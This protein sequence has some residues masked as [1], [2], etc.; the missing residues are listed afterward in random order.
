MTSHHPHPTNAA[1]TMANRNERATSSMPKWLLPI[2]KRRR[3]NIGPAVFPASTSA[4][5]SGSNHDHMRTQ[6]RPGMP[7]HEAEPSATAHHQSISTSPSF[8]LAADNS[9]ACA[10]KRKAPDVAPRNGIWIS[11][12]EGVNIM[13]QAEMALK[14]SRRRV[15]PSGSESHSKSAWIVAN[16]S[17][18]GGFF[19]LLLLP[20]VVLIIFRD[21]YRDLTPLFKQS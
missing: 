19:R 1:P 9:V 4:Q 21:R 12:D 5:T 7:Q 17:N 11:Q 15:T 10:A 18:D 16:D 20:N 2:N 13:M 3:S 8:A 6:C 14:K